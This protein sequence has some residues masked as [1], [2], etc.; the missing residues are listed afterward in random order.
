[1]TDLQH[2]Q[3]VKGVTEQFKDVLEQSPQAIYL[4]LDDVHKVCNRGFSDMLGYASPQQWAETEAPWPM[5]SK[6]TV[7]P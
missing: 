2:E 4:Y 7:P 3:L 6:P 5:S 1:M